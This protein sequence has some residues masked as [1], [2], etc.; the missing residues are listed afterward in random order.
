MKD[1]EIKIKLSSHEILTG[2]L[3]IPGDAKGLVIFAH[4]SGSSR[5]SPRNK[6]VAT[7]LNNR[8]MATLLTDLLLPS[9]D[10]VYENRFNIALISDRL[11]KITEW[12]MKQSSLQL[13]PVGYFGASTGAAAALQ[14]A[15]ALGNK[16]NAVVSRGG[17]P[18]L[19]GHALR[20]VKAPTQF[21]IGAF[22]DRVIELNEQ[23]YDKMSC[24]KKIEIV[25]G[26]SHLFEEAGTL[27]KA[28]QLAAD[29]LEQ[30]LQTH[31]LLHSKT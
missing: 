13:L 26:A 11:V 5:L 20:K 25:P 28:A 29:W 15:A 14:A 17:R 1:N 19:A 2:D 18:D 8:G 4:G 10:E 22:D 27:E 24:K 23:A 16:I 3:Q 12:T 9:E 7:I 30:H 6:Y 31:T 21:I